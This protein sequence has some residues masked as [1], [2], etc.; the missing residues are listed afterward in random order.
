[1]RASLLGLLALLLGT[2]F[3]IRNKKLLSVP[4][5]LDD[6]LGRTR[7]IVRRS[8]GAAMLELLDIDIVRIGGLGPVFE[9][10]RSLGTALVVR[11][12]Q[13]MVSKR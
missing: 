8:R 13:W 11:V 7:S 12:R 5:L 1:M 6:Q 10:A 3:A 4:H 9:S 2:M